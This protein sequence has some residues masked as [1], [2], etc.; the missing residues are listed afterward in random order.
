VA[1][2]IAA[3]VRHRPSSLSNTAN[4]RL[5]VHHP[6]TKQVTAYCG[7]PP[8]ALPHKLNCSKRDPADLWA[9]VWR[10]PLPPSCVHCGHEAAA[11]FVGALNIRARGA[12]FPRSRG[13]LSCLLAIG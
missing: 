3:D 12:E 9:G 6:N 1:K 7:I 11:D 5:L 10:L 2:K 13:S 4:P 8:P